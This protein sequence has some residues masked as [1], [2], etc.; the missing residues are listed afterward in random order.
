MR[1]MKNWAKRHL[2]AR[3]GK[4]GGGR[5]GRMEDVIPDKMKKR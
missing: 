3:N 5:V 1:S 4:S 2:I